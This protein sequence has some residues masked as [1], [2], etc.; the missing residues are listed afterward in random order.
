VSYWRSLA[1]AVS[2]RSP[3]LEA[4]LP[5]L[6]A[7]DAATIAAMSGWTARGR[8][9]KTYAS[10]SREGYEQNLCAY[11]A[12]NEIAM[13][14]GSVPLTLFRGDVEVPEHEM[15]Q[16]LETPNRSSSRSRFMRDAVS[17][18]LLD[19]NMFL[20]G[21][22][23]SG[24]DPAKGNPPRA[25]YALRPDR[26]TVDRTPALAGGITRYT[27]RGSDQAERPGSRV[28]TVA[29]VD[30][31]SPIL[32]A[33]TFHPLDDLRGQAPMLSARA[34]IDR[35]NL[36][37]EWNSNLIRNGASPSGHLF[38]EPGKDGLPAVLPEGERARVLAEADELLSGPRN[39]GK[40]RVVEGGLRWVQTGLSPKDLEWNE[41]K[42]SAARD[43][44]SA[45][46]FPAFLLGIPG[47]N[48]YSNQRE[49]RA[50]LWE[51]TIIPLA[52]MLAEE[53]TAWLAP[54]WGEDL[55][56]RLNLDEVTALAVRREAVWDRV[57]NVDWLTT[58]EKR[59]ETGFEDLGVP[60]SD[61]VL[62]SAVL[63]P[64][65][66]SEQSVQLRDP[67]EGGE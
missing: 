63:V 22:T 27:Y 56:L 62:V 18:L 21:V 38:V 25:M 16:L 17:Y 59:G 20:E 43:V 66:L 35:F 3:T 9:G 29:D 36:A 5:V 19:G 61:D 4:V 65:G 26:V 6:K 52:A 67:D 8:V 60:G 46:G 54:F 47:D 55:V 53:L 34:A 58:D 30:E 31:T 10:L 39:A 24:G 11:R 64:L 42:N 51:N 28:W 15:L 23:F 50:A 45:L 41:A 49:A 13:G 7:L 37:E 44:C 2:G 48:T 12:I 40:V 57:K 14:V 32:H 1:R 33:K